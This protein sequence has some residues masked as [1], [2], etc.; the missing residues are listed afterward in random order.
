MNYRIVLKLIGKL[1]LVL[2]AA[3]ALPLCVALLY[4]ETPVPFFLAIGISLLFGFVLSGI[5]APGGFFAR[6]G[7]VAVA[8]IWFVMGV[9]GALPF[10]FSGWFSSY[11]DCFFETVSGFTTTGASILTAIEPLPRGILFWRSF[12]HWLGG[13]GVLIL[14]LA[15]L[16]KLG[17][18]TFHLMRA[19][20]PGPTK[21]KLV[22]KLSESS[23]ILYL[24]YTALTAA[25]VLALRIA[26]LPLYDAAVTAFGTA[27]TGGFSVMNAS[28]GAY[29]NPAAEIIITI[30]LFLFSMNFTLYFLLLSG[31]IRQVLKSS[32]L[33][34]FSF[35]WFAAAAVLILDIRPLYETLG[36]TVR[37]A[38]FQ[39]ATMISTAGF[40]T[41]D[42][43]LWPSTAKMVLFLLMVCG[44]CAGS[45]GGGIKAGRIVIFLKSIRR[46]VQQ[47]LHPRSVSVVKLDGHAL[48]E[49]TV[50][51][52]L[53]FLVTYIAIAFLGA[54]FVAQDGFSFATNITAVFSALGNIG[55]GLDMVG[56]AGNFAAFSAPSKLLLSVCMIMGRIEIFP[57]LVLFSPRT[58]KVN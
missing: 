20:S 47:I 35:L 33:R 38:F 46:E 36:E 4:R 6:E 26:G 15:L 24:I 2:A 5:K 44:A 16:P 11:V 34:L 56:S 10:Y 7:F 19:E 12:T 18:R 30:F 23:K 51:T 40:A 22:P 27:G 58:W 1:L 8:A 28:I 48:D 50:R 53:V 45:T 9:F 29:H 49:G 55:P 32:E 31:K 41:A 39:V 54:V 43:D 42:F 57:I 25:L 3:M 21:S 37:A 52:A 17:L 14:A 13:M